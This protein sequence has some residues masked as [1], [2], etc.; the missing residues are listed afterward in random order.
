MTTLLI[1][2]LNFIGFT[3]CKAW[4]EGAYKWYEDPSNMSQF[5]SSLMIVMYGMWNINIFSLL[6]LFAPSHKQG[7]LNESLTVCEKEED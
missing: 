5:T 6:F 3:I 7:T 4:V 2:H 1:A